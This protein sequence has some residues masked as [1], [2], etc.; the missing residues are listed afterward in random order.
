MSGRWRWSWK[1]GGRVALELYVV[2][3][4][5]GWGWSCKVNGLRT[6]HATSREYFYPDWEIEDID[7]ID[8][9]STFH[10]SILKGAVL[11]SRV[12]MCSIPRLGTGD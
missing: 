12:S 2:Q 4:T 1:S 10:S 8:Y 5:R 7:N 11:I 6:K 3:G 9:L